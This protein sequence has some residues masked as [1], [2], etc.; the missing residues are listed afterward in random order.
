MMKK[1]ATSSDS[2]VPSTVI[3]SEDFV[4]NT[5]YL[6]P[7]F[8][9]YKGHLVRYNTKTPI[10]SLWSL[11]ATSN[12]ILQSRCAWI[13]IMYMVCLGIVSFLLV[14]FGGWAKSLTVDDLAT[15]VRVLVSFVLGGYILTCLIM[16]QETCAH[17]QRVVNQLISLMKIIDTVPNEEVTEETRSDILCQCRLILQMLFFNGSRRT[18]LNT[19]VNEG[20]L[21][22]EKCT[23]LDTIP[24]G[25]R[26][27]VLCSWLD[28]S[29]I[30]I[31][32]HEKC[33]TI[34]DTV[35][36]PSRN[37][38]D[39]YYM[40]LPFMYTHAVYWALQ[41]IFMALACQTGIMLAIYRA[42]KS[43][44]DG[45]FED[46]DDKPVHPNLWLTNASFGLIVSKIIFILFANGL[47]QVCERIQNP[48]DNR[49][50]SLCR[51][52]HDGILVESSNSYRNAI[53]AFK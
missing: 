50:S 11:F 3:N 33:S 1:M 37:L 47:L 8:T 28:Q 52:L 43:T 21:A 14:H 10:Y 31:N 35:R 30:K 27:D 22:V 44:G 12:T 26:S 20:K 2:N 34:V 9:Q 7:T 17:V 32:H 45:A 18:D 39:S 19:L 24:I 4:T 42:T 16:W 29:L 53:R 6:G 13:Q 5:S 23:Y 48:L 40:Q 38:A 51:H 36:S 41:F 15:E 46:D 49:K 25:A